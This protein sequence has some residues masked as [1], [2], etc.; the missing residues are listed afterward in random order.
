[1]YSRAPCPLAP[2]IPTSRGDEGVITPVPIFWLDYSL[3]L[4]CGASK[5]IHSPLF[6]HLMKFIQKKSRR[7]GEKVFK[8]FKSLRTLAFQRSLSWF[9]SH[10]TLRTLILPSPLYSLS[11]WSTVRD[12]DNR[13]PDHSSVRYKAMRC[14]RSHSSFF[15]PSTL[16]SKKRSR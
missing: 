13:F 5:F 16:R 9:L 6:S 14:L 2:H 12:A 15:R 1:M 11:S 3:F 8:D 4:T 10:T 7:R